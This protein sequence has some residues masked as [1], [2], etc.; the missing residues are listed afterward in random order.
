M[1]GN[2][3]LSRR[4]ERMQ[5]AA[6]DL[7]DT[8]AGIG[9]QTR[10]RKLE[11]EDR[12][13]ASE[14]RASANKAR[15]TQQQVADLQLGKFQREDAARQEAEGLAGQLT[16]FGQAV[17]QNEIQAP[18]DGALPGFQGM[19]SERPAVDTAG[20]SLKDRLR[21]QWM[22]AD[23]KSKGESAAFTAADV[24]R[25]RDEGAAK[26]K[27]EAE[28]RDLDIQGKKVDIA[29]KE[30]GNKKTGL[31]LKKLQA[32]I[33]ALA[34]G[35]IDPEKAYAIEDKISS[36]YIAQNSAFSEMGDAIG[37]IRVSAQEPSGA[38]DMSLIYGYMKILDPKTGIKEGEVASAQDAGSI[39]QSILAAYNKAVSGVKLDPKV[40]ADFVKRAEM[41]YGEADR[42]Y[43]QSRSN[44]QK[45]ATSYGVDP[46]RATPDLRRVNVGQ[47]SGGGPKSFKSA[48]EAMA[49]GLAPGTVVM[50]NGVEA[51][52]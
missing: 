35:G 34:K 18:S 2:I 13:A 40:R 19:R 27:L 24:K 49:A 6:R 47:T 50:I 26:K 30:A 4:L 16:D 38:G 43:T 9:E 31:E 44:F 11:D 33:D 48:R 36:K 7:G 17:P 42:A 20:E 29:G 39:P 3:I 12:L 14:D 21:A 52:M 41:L 45:L 46:E 1:A 32:E 25:Q 15:A 8:F 37:R 23:A 5:A 22:N 28:D 51:E 10:K